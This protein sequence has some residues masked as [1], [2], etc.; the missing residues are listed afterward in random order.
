LVIGVVL[1]ASCSSG[2][3]HTSTEGSTTTPN[4]KSATQALK[5]GTVWM[6]TWAPAAQVDKKTK[7]K[8]LE[9][10]QKYV[11]RAYLAPLN[12]GNVDPLYD[13]LF[14]PQLRA[15]AT[16]ADRKALTDDPTGKARIYSQTATPVNFSALAD[17]SGNVLYVA[18]NFDVK[19]NGTFDT[20]KASIAHDVEL[21][22]APKGKDWTIIAYRVHTTRKLP[23]AKTTTTTT[24]KRSTS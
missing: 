13:G 24:A 15:A 12:T 5:A 2:G 7:Q 19:V 21:T 18:T 6:E 11:D 23:H 1:V 9:A 14:D 22:F 16:G 17:G 8:I 3:K 10:A 20:G 4:E